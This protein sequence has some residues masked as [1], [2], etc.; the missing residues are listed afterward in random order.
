MNLNTKLQLNNE[1]MLNNR[2]VVPP[3]ASQ[4]ADKRGFVTKKTQDHYKRLTLS[5]AALIMLEYTFVHISGKSEDNQLGLSSDEH[6][7]GLS[8]IAKIIESANLTPAIQLTHAGGK[9]SRSLTDGSMISPSAIRIPTKAN[10]LDI[11]DRASLDQIYFLKKSFIESSVRAYKAGFKIIELHS[12]HGYGLNQWLSPITN[13]RND[14]YGGDLFSRSR[15]LLEIIDEIK[16]RLPH[17]LLSVRIPGMD[18]FQGGFS[19]NESI[20]LSRILESH[21]VDII[22]VSSGIGGWKRPRQRYGEGYLVDDAKAIQKAIHIPVIGVGGIKTKNY[23][24]D[25]LDKGF[26]SLAAVGRA[27]LNNPDWGSDIGLI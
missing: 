21:D 5:R 6:I 10:D 11:P 1:I 25:S 4:T 19:I 15:L 23:I 9:T 14:L 8:N 22:N 24:N 3:M 26:F 16:R 7:Q 2:I 20:Q 27:I 18:H 13:Q 17:I 12:A